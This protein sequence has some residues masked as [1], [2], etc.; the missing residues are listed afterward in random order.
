MAKDVKDFPSGFNGDKAYAQ[1]RLGVTF[2]F[3]LS[4]K[5]DSGLPE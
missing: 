2:Y 4:E 1:F 3:S 5:I